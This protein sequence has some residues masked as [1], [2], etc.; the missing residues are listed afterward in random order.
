[1]S[2]P[3]PE[4][5]DHLQALFM[6]DL[7]SGAYLAGVDRGWWRAREFAWPFAVIELAL[8]LRPGS[9]EWLALRFHLEGY[10]EAP[11]AQP[12]DV[13]AGAPLPP[14]RWPGGSERITMAFNPNW[15]QDA[16]YIPMDRE[17]LAGHPGWRTQHACHIWDPSKD[18]TQY[19][20]LVRDLLHNEGYT[21]ARGS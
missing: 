14:A 20:R 10:P 21:G 6:G 9:D 7:R 19:L 12:W 15:R 5:V 1:M 8:P 18:I 3:T 2:T 11:T 4:N 17:A 13:A 16:L